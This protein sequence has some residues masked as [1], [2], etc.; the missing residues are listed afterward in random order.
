[1]PGG[2]IG[3]S[4]IL[5]A[6]ARF[7]S[8]RVTNEFFPSTLT[9]DSELADERTFRW[10]DATGPGIAALKHGWAPM[11]LIQ[12]FAGCLVVAYYQIPGL[13][14]SLRALEELKSHGGPPFALASGA[15]AGGLVPQLAKLLTG[16]VTS[17]GRRFWLQM[18]FT[19][20]V[21]A[22]VSLQIDYFYQFQAFMFGSQHDGLTVI[23]KDLVDM[24]IFAPFISIP[25]A[26]ILFEWRNAG[27]SA[28]DLGHRLRS[29]FFR[30]KIVPAL[31]P[32]WAFWIPMLLCVYAMPPN[33]Q[34][35]LAQL[36]EA[37]WAVLFI[38]IATDAE[39]Y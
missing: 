34:F 22:I 36:A 20:A 21:Y 28:T 2:S 6:N 37:S 1:V 19:G 25:T 30:S 5:I 35:P 32:C 13:R 17:F 4:S 15:I 8:V 14:M 39:L 23:K 29:Q 7:S 10:R 16:R 24:A 27:F 11:L 18:L 26:V 3:T 31:I 33:L 9:K 38:F 12:F